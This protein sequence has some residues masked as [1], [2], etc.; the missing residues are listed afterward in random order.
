MWT[1]NPEGTFC[2][3]VTTLETPLNCVMVQYNT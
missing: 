2:W 3:M 1:I